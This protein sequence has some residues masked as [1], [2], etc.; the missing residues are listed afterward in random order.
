MGL[1]GL[2]M[3]LEGQSSVLRCDIF[4]PWMSTLP[5]L[6]QPDERSLRILADHLRASIVIIADGV[7]PSNTGRGYVL[8]RL[9]RRALTILWRDDGTRS[10][11]DLP[12]PLIQDTLSRFG[13]DNCTVRDVLQEEEQRF[14]RL[15][16]RGRKVLAQ[17]EP[18]RQ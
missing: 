16:S 13:Q 11:R 2:L 15:L 7:R 12:D 5:G 6:W 1:E 8:R 18:E 14:A 17:F 3:V 4:E 9:L 10:L